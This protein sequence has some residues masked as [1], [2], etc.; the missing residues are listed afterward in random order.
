METRAQVECFHDVA[1]PGGFLP[2]YNDVGHWK[3]DSMQRQSVE[4]WSGGF[5]L[6]GQCF[7]NRNL[8]LDPRKFE[9]QLLYHVSNNKQRTIS[10]KKMI[11]PSEDAD[12]FKLNYEMPFAASGKYN[13]V[14]S[15][16]IL[17]GISKV[18]TNGRYISLFLATG[19]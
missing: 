3:G 2:P 9:R 13:E 19:A 15:S 18:L 16:E 12:D 7:L 14:S 4:F 1:C 5:Q 8:S 11:R 6:F 17:S 10:P